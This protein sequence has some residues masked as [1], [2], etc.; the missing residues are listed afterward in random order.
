[1][2]SYLLPDRVVEVKP[3]DMPADNPAVTRYDVEA[4]LE[5]VMEFYRKRGYKVV[6]NPKGASVF[7]RSGDGILQILRGKGRKIRILA[8]TQT[9][10]P[11]SDEDPSKVENLD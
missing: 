5:E 4:S 11:G 10:N 1:M 7:P 2:G 3:A 6:R 8:I 9:T